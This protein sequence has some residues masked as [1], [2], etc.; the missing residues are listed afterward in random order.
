MGLRSEHKQL[1]VG[2]NHSQKSTAINFAGGQHLFHTSNTTHATHPL[3]LKGTFPST[4]VKKKKI[5]QN[6]GWGCSSVGRASDRHDV[7]AEFDSPVR[8][9]IFLS[10]N[11]QCRLSYG[12]RTPPCAIARIYICVHVKDPVVHVRVRWIMETLGSAI[13]SQ[14]SFPW[15][16]T[17][18][19]IQL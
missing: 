7:D 11:I 6:L 10:V 2:V 14:L 1:T 8:Q 17:G 5:A 9:G 15:N 3:T 16:A 18:R 12:V 19:T 13:P 4:W